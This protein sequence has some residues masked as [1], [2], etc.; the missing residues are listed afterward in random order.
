MWK[1]GDYGEVS[2]RDKIKAEIYA[3]GPIACGV[4][5]TDKL[6]AYTGG[7]YQEYSESPMV[8]FI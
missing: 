5:A 3:N 2:G 8:T 7:I 1:V 4:M 6:D